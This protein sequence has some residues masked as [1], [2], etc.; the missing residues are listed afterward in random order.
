MMLINLSTM[1]LQLIMLVHVL[2]EFFPCLTH[3]IEIFS[4]KEFLLS[5]D[6]SS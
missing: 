6:A 5:N 3:C 1:S 4:A 2:L